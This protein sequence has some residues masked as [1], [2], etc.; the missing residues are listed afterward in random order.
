MPPTQN[1]DNRKGPTSGL[2]SLLADVCDPPSECFQYETINFS[3]H[4]EILD[5]EGRIARFSRHQRIRFLEDGVGVFVDR[6]WGDGVLFA[7]YSARSMRILDA[8]PTR[9]GY[10]VVLTLPRPF[11]KGE[12][13][14][15]VTQRRIVGAFIDD[16]AYWDSAMAVPTELLTI[17]VFA[18]RGRDL[19]RPEVVAPLR[20]D[21][22]AKHRPGSLHFR[23]RH[24]AIH[25]PYQL[26]WSWQ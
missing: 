12:T 2:S 1:E 18:P 9:K 14:D 5:R 25:I 26:A 8:I 15:I 6:I 19:R 24:P 7:A 3:G 11:I 17:D 13:F 10:A 4:V 16:H 20:G 23:V 22:D 21:I